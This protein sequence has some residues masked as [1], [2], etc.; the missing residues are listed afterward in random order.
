MLSCWSLPEDI[1]SLVTEYNQ[2]ESYKHAPL[3]TRKVKIRTVDPWYNKEIADEKRECRRLE[4]KCQKSKTPI[5]FNIYR[6]L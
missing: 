4:R 5:N 6:S 1:N 3:Q 2:W